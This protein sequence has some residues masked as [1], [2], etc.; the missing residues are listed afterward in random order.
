MEYIEFWAVLFITFI[1]LLYFL[2]SKLYSKIFILEKM[3]YFERYINSRNILEFYSEAEFILKSYKDLPLPVRF[4]I[5][6]N[7]F[8]DL[9]YFIDDKIST[10]VKPPKYK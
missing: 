1:F 4:I 10:E 9:I 5:R 3:L 2:L 8:E 6:R 7:Y